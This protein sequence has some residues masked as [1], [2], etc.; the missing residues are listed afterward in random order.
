MLTKYAFLKS[1]RH[2]FVQGYH[3]EYV[4][5]QDIH[6][7]VAMWSLESKRQGQLPV[8]NCVGTKHVAVPMPR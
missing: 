4:F 1:M 2:L 6:V 8:L 7:V 3:A 5:Q